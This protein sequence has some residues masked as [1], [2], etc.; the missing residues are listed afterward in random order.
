MKIFSLTITILILSFSLLSQSNFNY[1]VY[2]KPIPI[3][4]LTGLHSYASA[5]SG[6]KILMI[7]GRK[8]GIHAR[9]PFNAFP[10]ASNND[11]LFVVDLETKSVWKRSL[12]ELSIP[13]QEQLQSTNMNHFQDA[14]TLVLVGGYAYSNT[15]QDHI[16]FPKMTTISVNNLISH[17]VNNEAIVSDFKQIEDQVFAN[18]GGN[19]NKIGSTFYLIGG[20]RFDGRY[21]PMNNPTFTQTYFDG[22]VK[23]KLNSSGVN[24]QYS[25]LETITD[26]I[27]LHRRDYNLLTQIGLLNEKKLV[28]SSGVF[29]ISE[30]LPFLYPVEISADTHVARTDFNQYLSNYHSAKSSLYSQSNQTN[31][32]LFFGGISQYYY[33]NGNLIN[34]PT[35]PFVKTISLLKNQNGVYE[36]F[37]M[38]TEMPS[39]K[40]AGANFFPSES[41]SKL[42]EEVILMDDFSGD[43]ITIGHIFGGI[44]SNSKSAFTDNQTDLTQADQNLYEVI[45]VKNANASIQTIPNKNK[46]KFEIFP[47]PNDGIL[48]FTYTLE[49]KSEIYFYITDLNGKIVDEGLLSKNKKGENK[50]KLTLDKSLANQELILT[51]SRDYIDF[52]S[53]KFILK[54]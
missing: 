46:F 53:K 5:Q 30:D 10:N 7:G 51:I 34:D 36:E 3:A 27:H 40:G 41:L 48:N 13:L 25:I 43:S 20:H 54:R 42:E 11:S 17:I 4:G 21:N 22:M 39:L 8:D 29:Q 9:Q 52:D 33:E 6:N 14:D 12:S 38:D 31:Y 2:L 37:K 35:A 1:S 16:T 18:T 32:T 50:C 19:L 47:N 45:L 26:P 44:E 15:A 49:E 23:F 28:I 24:I